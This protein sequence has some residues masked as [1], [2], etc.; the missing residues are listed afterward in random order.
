MG[1]DLLST[2]IEQI[3]ATTQDANSVSVMNH[4]GTAGKPVDQYSAV[5]NKYGWVGGDGS[6]QLP[7][8]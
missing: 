4:Q 6:Q 3:Q 1:I 5:K 7:R 8:Y 2:P